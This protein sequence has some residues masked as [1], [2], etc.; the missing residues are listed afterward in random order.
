MRSI[1]TAK[2]AKKKVLVRVDYNVPLNTVGKKITVADD[3]RLT[4]S[5]PT[6]THLKKN[7]ARI[8]LISH[9]GRPDGKVVEGLSL[10]PVARKLSQLVND[11]VVFCDQLVGSKPKQIIDKLSPGKIVLLQNTRFY[12][13]ETKNDTKLAKKTGP[14]GRFVCE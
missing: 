5:L 12:P 2:V 10:E 13:G 9:L 6:L 14:D 3:V 11:E 1:Q 4:A 8:I 7:R